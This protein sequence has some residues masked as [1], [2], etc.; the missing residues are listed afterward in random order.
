[1]ITV[2]GIGLLFGTVVL[3]SH[4]LGRGWWRAGAEHRRVGYAAGTSY[5]IESIAFGTISFFAGILGAMALAA[6]TMQHIVFAL[7][8]MTARWSVGRGW[9]W[10]FSRSAAAASHCCSG[11]HRSR[12][13]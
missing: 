9:G 1:M 5:G 8:F 7:I 12:A 11:P 6:Y 3:T 2:T 13:C 4:A 10:S